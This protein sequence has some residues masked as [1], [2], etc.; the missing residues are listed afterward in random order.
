MGLFL[1]R[2]LKISIIKHLK[3]QR[4]PVNQVCF[5]ILLDVPQITCNAFCQIILVNNCYYAILVL[6][7]FVMFLYNGD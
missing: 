6:L 4:R 5:Y 1:A 3:C 2:E 7:I